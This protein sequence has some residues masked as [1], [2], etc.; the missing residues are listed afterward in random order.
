VSADARSLLRYSEGAA[1]LVDERG[2]RVQV[3][4][5]SPLTEADAATYLLG[6]VFA[7]ILRLQ[8]I[9][10]VTRSR[11]ALMPLHC[12]LVPETAALGPEA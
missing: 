2:S 8:G 6:P 10:C 11:A 5:A 7:F 4:W 3:R 12:C 1:Y 9:T